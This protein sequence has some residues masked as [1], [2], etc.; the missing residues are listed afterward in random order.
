MV[1]KSNKKGSDDVE[2]GA[3]TSAN[4]QGTISQ[5]CTPESTQQIT[6]EVEPQLLLVKVEKKCK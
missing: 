6:T 3:S 2:K 5:I 4:T 1:K